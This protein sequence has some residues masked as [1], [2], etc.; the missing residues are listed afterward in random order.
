MKLQLRCQPRLW[1]SE[2]LSG[3]GRSSFKM[4]YTDGKLVLAISRGP[5]FLGT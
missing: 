2:D 4:T 5:Q 3:T 1:L